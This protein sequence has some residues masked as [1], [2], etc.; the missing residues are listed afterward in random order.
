MKFLLPVTVILAILGGPVMASADE[1]ITFG[2]FGTVTVYR[3]AGTPRSV[4]LFL[5]GDGGWNLGVVGMARQLVQQGALV[6]GIDFPAYLKALEAG[7]ESCAYPAADLEQLGHY[8]EAQ[9]GFPKFLRPILVGYSSGATAA[10]ATLVQSPSGTFAGGVALGFCPDLDIKKA[11][12]RGS[13]LASTPRKDGHGVDFLPAAHG[14]G[15]LVILQGEID[16]VCDAQAT[17]AFAARL[18]DTDLVMLPRVGHG[19]SVEKNW[20]PQFLDA[21]RKVS[22]GAAS[23]AAVPATV[24]G[25][26]PAAGEGSVDDLPLTLVHPAAGGGRQLAIMLSGDGGWAGLDKSVAEALAERGV[27]VVGWDSLSYFWQART[28]AGASADLAAVLRH[29]IAADGRDSVILVGYSQ[30]ADTLPFMFNGLPAELARAIRRVVLIAPAKSATF[31]FHVS[32]WLGKDPPG[33]ATG[34]EVARIPG[35]QLT[36]L[37]GAEEDDSL[38]R[39]LDRNKYRVIELP[40]GHH[41]AGDYDTLARTILQDLP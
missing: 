19:Y 16:Q 4:V 25:A 31:E 2:R 36:C 11:W 22:A 27:E 8:I 29:F 9:L 10:Y 21:W 7:G 18:A 17:Q 38:C 33:V 1:T 20:V 13:G 35:E 23:P 37:Y 30:G 41:F 6:L 3:P 39:E 32:T 15:E 24:A 12:C 40:G 5:S 34:P 28:P 14:S 26:V